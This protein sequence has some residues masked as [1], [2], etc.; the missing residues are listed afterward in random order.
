MNKRNDFCPTFTIGYLDDKGDL[1][2]VATFNNR[3]MNL[4]PLD[5][6][7]MVN[8]TVENFTEWSGKTIIRYERQD[9]PDTVQVE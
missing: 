3:L 9:T 5:F 6:E 4:A 1:V 7:Y 8:R 2:V